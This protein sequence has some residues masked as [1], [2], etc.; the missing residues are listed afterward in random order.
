M[1]LILESGGVKKI[2]VSNFN[3]AELSK[4]MDQATIQPEIV[5]N[6]CQK[7][8]DYDQSVRQMCAQAQVHVVQT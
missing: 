4:L 8:H 3:A 5:Q 6:R 7:K 2:G 1:E